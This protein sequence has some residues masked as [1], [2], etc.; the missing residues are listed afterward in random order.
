MCGRVIPVRRTR[1]VECAAKHAKER[2][3]GYNQCYYQD[4]R[5]DINEQRRNQRRKARKLAR[6][7]LAAADARDAAAR[8]ENDDQLSSWEIGLEEGL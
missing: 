7:V 2:R 8:R 6:E 4:N 5:Q 1:C 3:V